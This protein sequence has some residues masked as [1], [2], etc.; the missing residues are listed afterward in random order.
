M[1]E[2]G[3]GGGTAQVATDLLT[4][5]ANEAGTTAD[6][7][8]TMLRNLVN[9]LLPLADAWQ[10]RGGTSF[11][12][13][14]LQLEEEMQTLNAALRSIAESMGIASTNYATAD[15]EMEADLLAAGAN[16]GQITRLMQD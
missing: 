7:L 6:G 2:E 9:N 4:S 1:F 16:A 5:G 11:Q 12:N 8:D 15:D 14:Q 3:G 13:V 10:G